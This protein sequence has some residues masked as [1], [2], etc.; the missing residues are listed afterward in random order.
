MTNMID[1]YRLAKTLG[2]GFSAKVKLAYDSE[3]NECALKIFNLT[4]S[5][6]GTENAMNLFK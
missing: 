3:N 6:I 4:N 2:A 1:N 5:D